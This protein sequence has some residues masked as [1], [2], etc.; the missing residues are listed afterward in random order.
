MI[1]WR[2]NWRLKAKNLHPGFDPASHR[3]PLRVAA[4]YDEHLLAKPCVRIRSPRAV[5]LRRVVTGIRPPFARNRISGP[6]V[7]AGQWDVGDVGDAAS[8]KPPGASP[9]S[10]Q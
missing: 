10:A 2:P 5:V 6:A 8:V 4:Q 9:P 7:D 3:I 1:G